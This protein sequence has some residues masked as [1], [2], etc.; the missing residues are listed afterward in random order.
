MS[1]PTRYKDT[2]VYDDQDGVGPQFGLFR[3]P[4]DLL[5]AGFS[6]YV[7]QRSDVGFLDRIAYRYYGD[8][9]LWWV[10]AYANGIFD[11]EFDVTVGTKVTIPN[12]EAVNAFVQRG[13]NN[14]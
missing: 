6:Y 13:G 4:A 3:E 1:D 5:S 14:A 8:E 2:L 10:I 11:P 9:S 12:V 7:I